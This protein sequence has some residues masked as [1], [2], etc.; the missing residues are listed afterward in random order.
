MKSILA[1]KKLNQQRRI[2]INFNFKKD[3]IGIDDSTANDSSSLTKET[4]KKVVSKLDNMKM[5]SSGFNSQNTTLANTKK[6]KNVSIESDPSSLINP[7]KNCVNKF[8]GD[9]N[10]RTT[11]LTKSIKFLKTNSAHFIAKKQAKNIANKMSQNVKS[12]SE[13]L[14]SSPPPLPKIPNLQNAKCNIQK[15][16]PLEISKVKDNKIKMITNQVSVTELSRIQSKISQSQTIKKPFVTVVKHTDPVVKETDL[17][18]RKD[19]DKT[20]KEGTVSELQKQLKLNI[21]ETER[22]KKELKFK[23]KLAKQIQEKEKLA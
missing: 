2:L 12:K 5:K 10:S 15:T 18:R 3:I 17:K 8:E 9:P 6:L 20:A 4:V 13:V 23:T 16:V 7:V 1:L 14:T 19:Q 21:E 11:P 22:L